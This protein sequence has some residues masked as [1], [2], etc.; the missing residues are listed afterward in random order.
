MPLSNVFEKLG[1]AVFESPFESKRLAKDAPEV[2]EIRLT[3]IDAIKN[4][5]HRVGAAQ[6]FPF[7]LVRIHLLG[8][9]EEQEP[10]FQSEF[11]LKYFADEL[12][13]A[14]KRGS[15]RFPANLAVEFLTNSRL[16]QEGEQWVTVETA[17][18][19]G[20]KAETVCERP[21]RLIVL[22]GSAN[23][24]EFV[25][26]R[27]RFNIGRG[28]EIFRSTGPSRRNEI[29]FLGNDEAGRTVSREH[30][31]IM[32]STATN[33]YRIFNDRVYQGEE[34][35]GIWIMREGL[36]FPVHHGPRGTLLQSGDEI[37]LGTAVVRFSVEAADA[38]E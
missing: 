6:V 18:R 36:S 12:K 7:D 31:H 30:A 27:A 33:E 11:L 5:S 29:S 23:Q 14:L 28:A 16:P 26:D 32:R 17:M 24:S 20:T 3:A 22:Q 1:R 15:Y 38:A 19:S 10:V 13:A 21:A 25:L 4:R 9:P 8:I 35:C 2:A 37:H 34:N